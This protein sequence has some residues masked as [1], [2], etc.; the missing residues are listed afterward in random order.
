MSDC[1]TV[2]RAC[3]KSGIRGATMTKSP[4]QWLHTPAGRRVVYTRALLIPR[5]RRSAGGVIIFGDSTM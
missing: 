4:P 3:L 1:Y 5:S 2:V